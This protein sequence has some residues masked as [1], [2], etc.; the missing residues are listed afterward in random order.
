MWLQDYL[1]KDVPNARV[2]IYGY[3]SQLQGSASCG[4]LTDY[5]KN[6]VNRLLSMRDSANVSTPLS[7]LT[8]TEIERALVSGSSYNLHRT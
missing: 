4:I 7:D 8:V 6:F 3:P 2:L 5:T 1:A